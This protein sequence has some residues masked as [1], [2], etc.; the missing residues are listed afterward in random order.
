[1][2]GTVAAMQLDDQGPRLMRTNARCCAQFPTKIVLLLAVGFLYLFIGGAIMS[3]L[4]AG[5]E[6]SAERQVS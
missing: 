2:M 5:H 4:E 6:R 1:M 3:E